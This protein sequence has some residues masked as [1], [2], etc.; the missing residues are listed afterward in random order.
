MH[1]LLYL[2]FWLTFILG[3]GAW[4]AIGL[5]LYLIFGNQYR[6]LDDINIVEDELPGMSGRKSD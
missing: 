3:L 5:M 2:L 6:R 1:E 4:V